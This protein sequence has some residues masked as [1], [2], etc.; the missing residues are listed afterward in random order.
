MCGIVGIWT[1]NKQGESELL[2]INDAV[3]RLKHRG[4]DHQDSKTYSNLALG[5]ARL[6]IIDTRES[7]NQPMLDETGRYCLVYNG[8]IFNYKEIRQGLELEGVRFTTNSDTEVL[9]HLLILKGIDGLERVNGFFAFIFYDQQE[10]KVLFARDR[11]GIKPLVIYEDEDKIILSSEMHALFAFDIDKTLDNSALNYYLRLSYSPAPTNM[12]TRCFK[13]IPG[14]AGEITEDGLKLH[15]YYKTIRQPFISGGFSESVKDLRSLLTQSVKDRL[16]SDVPLGSFL[17]GGVDSSIVSAIASRHKEDLETFSIGFDH[18]YFNE[19]GHAKV[20]AEHIGSKH[21]E[22]IIGKEEFVSNFDE[23]LDRIDEPFADSSAFAVYFLS[24]KTKEHVTVALSG[25]GAD[26]LFGGYRKHRAELM[27]REMSVSKE[28]GIRFLSKVFKSDRSSRSDKWGDFNRKI[29]KLKN[30]LELSNTERY[31]EWCCFSSKMDVFDLLEPSHRE[32]AGWKGAEIEN[33]NDVL[34]AD[35]LMVLPNDMLKKVDLMSMANQLEV[36]T[37]FLDHRI[38]EL[39]NALPLKFKLNQKTGKIILKEA[40]R[41]YLPEGIL[42]RPKQGFE[43]PLQDWLGEKLDEI[44]ASQLFTKDYINEQGIFDFEYI[45]FLSKNI[46]SKQF[47]DKI[48][49]VWSLIVF[50]HW[51]NKYVKA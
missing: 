6:S 32:E 20:V 31:F 9:L 1:K 17:S 10:N 43:I 25:D 12:L 36:R 22:F 2:K 14:Q 44:M 5:H 26:E 51:Y 29:N 8:E 48:Y 3:S 33:M 41:E 11:M 46:R 39:A 13:I 15:R 35:Q 30:G 19:S 37:P 49:L 50:Q 34:I 27:I 18:P 42:S 40:F 7:A 23:F 45:Q 21:H 24:K 4:P 16:I 47:G 38:V 28:R